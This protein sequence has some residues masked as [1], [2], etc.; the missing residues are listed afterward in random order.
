MNKYHE[1]WLE[2]KQQMVKQTRVSATTYT[3]TEILILM[4]SIETDVAFGIEMEKGEIK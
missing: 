2:L 3:P 4:D 1:M